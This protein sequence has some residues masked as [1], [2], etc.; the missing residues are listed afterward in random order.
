MTDRQNPTAARNK[1]EVHTEL[2]RQGAG[3]DTDAPAKPA[4]RSRIDLVGQ[5][6]DDDLFNDM[7]V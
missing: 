2:R 1:D 7:P 6:D 3:A 5:E 4:A